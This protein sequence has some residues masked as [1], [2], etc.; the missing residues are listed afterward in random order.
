MYVSDIVLLEELTEDQRNDD[1]LIAGCVGGALLKDDY[2]KIINDAGFK[3]NIL[4]EDLDIS[5]RQYQ[6]I[7]L[8]SLKVECYK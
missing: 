6:G 3:Y 8:E 2:L 4:D 5:K 7:N 1:E